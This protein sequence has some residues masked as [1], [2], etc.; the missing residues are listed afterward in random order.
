MKC[1]LLLLSAAFILSSCSKSKDAE[2]EI[3]MTDPKTL[4]LKYD[5]EHQFVMKKGNEITAG[6]LF[7]WSSSD[8]N[9]GT[10]AYDGKFKGRKIGTTVVKATAGGKEFMSTVTITPYSQIIKEPSFD[11]GSDKAAIK[12]KT[13][14]L[15]TEEFDNYLVYAGNNSAINRIIYFFQDGLLASVAIDFADTDEIEKEVTTFY[16][17]R[18]PIPVLT[19]TGGNVY[20][21]DEKTQGIFLDRNDSI[22]F[23]AS[24]GRVI[25]TNGRLSADIKKIDQSILKR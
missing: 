22:G 18:Y 24:Y 16:K 13:T 19:Q 20:I 12:A 9:V 11:F 6:N 25:L 5:Q 14:Q 23:Y 21:N 1:F 7:G 8:Q 15:L 10:V 4:E 17:E 3:T 2:P